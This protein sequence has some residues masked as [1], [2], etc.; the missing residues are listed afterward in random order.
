MPQITHAV[1][2]DGYT[3][4]GSSV[5]TS[6]TGDNAV[7]EIELNGTNA[8]TGSAASGVTLIGSGAAGSTIKGLVINR[9]GGN[10][11]N[12]QVGADG[13]AVVGNFLG[14]DT[15]GTVNRGNVFDGVFDLGTNDTIGGTAAADRNIIAFN[16]SAG[17]Q[18]QTASGQSLMPLA[19][20]LSAIRFTTTPTLES[21]WLAARRTPI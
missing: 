3:Q 16:G 14:T 13:V 8:G 7:I 12:L 15:G 9:F 6:A 2:I 20:E 11:V 1:D 19:I 5:N 18:V 17:V 10:A 21:I 4:A